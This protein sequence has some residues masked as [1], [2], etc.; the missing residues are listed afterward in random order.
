MATASVRPDDTLPV[1]PEGARSGEDPLGDVGPYELLHEL[2]QGGMGCVYLARE[3]GEEGFTRLVAL[4]RIHDHLAREQAFIHMFL[5]EARIAS[6]IQH[7]HVCTVLDF[8]RAGSAYFIAM[9]YLRGLPVSE[10]LRELGTRPPHMSPERFAFCAHLLAQACEGLHAAHELRDSE[11]KLM[12]VVHRDVSPHN[13]FVTFDGTLRVLDF[14]IARAANRLA[15][16][17]TG[18][19]KGK[20]AYM[21]PEQALGKVVDRRADVFSVGVVLWELC[22]LTRLFRRDSPAETILLVV[23]EETPTPSSVCPDVPPPLEQICMKALSRDPADRYP[24]ARQMGRALARA[25]A[26]I[27][28]TVTAGDIADWMAD[29]FPGRPE[30][31]TS[32]LLTHTK[33][34]PGPGDVTAMRAKITRS[35]TAHSLRRGIPVLGT[36]AMVVVAAAGAFAVARVTSPP[37]ED[38]RSLPPTLSGRTLPEPNRTPPVKPAEDS[39]LEPADMVFDVPEEPDLETAPPEVETPDPTPGV[40]RPGRARRRAVAATG[41]RGRVRFSGPREIWGS[42]IYHRNRRVGRLPGVVELPVGAQTVEIAVE[43][44]PRIRQRVDVTAGRETRVLVP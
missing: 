32:L 30:Q 9:E 27:G 4:K 33:D 39:D 31:S 2:A 17:T 3:R 29:L 6:R 26:A 10:V 16:S 36:V 38:V 7:P 14:G 25:A 37:A 35:A 28:P 42:I 18:R 34:P 1:A 12:D 21:A 40:A 11:G 15:E 8:G 41:R 5:D 22:T 43:G 19:V 44:R 13:L 24:N 20:F 23:N